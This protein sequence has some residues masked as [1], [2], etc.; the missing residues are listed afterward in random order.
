MWSAYVTSQPTLRHNPRYVTP[1]TIHYVPIHVTSRPALRHNPLRP[2]PRYVT[3]SCNGWEI[4]N[5]WEYIAVVIIT[6]V[7]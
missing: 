7:S 1:S 4:E 3:S 2:N 5:G 6:A